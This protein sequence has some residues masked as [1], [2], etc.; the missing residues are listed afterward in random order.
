MEEGW[1]QCAYTQLPP[2][3]KRLLETVDRNM[4]TKALSLKRKENR[5]EP[6]KR[7]VKAARKNVRSELATLSE[8]GYSRK[9]ILTSFIPGVGAG[10]KT[11]GQI[12]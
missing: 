8:Q 10:R 1:H 9:D 4:G 11:A 5:K 7:N 12:P 2:R 6:S 3:L